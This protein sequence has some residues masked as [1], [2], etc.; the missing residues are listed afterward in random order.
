MERWP[1]GSTP[2]DQGRW[3]TDH[4]DGTLMGHLG[5]RVLEVSKEKTVVELPVHPG[6]ATPSGHVHAGSMVSLA[7]TA[8]TYAAVAA[9]GRDITLDEI[10]VAVS[11]STQIVANVRTGTLRAESM[12]AHPGRTLV[13]V[14]TRVT[15]DDGKLLALVNSTHF[16]R[17][18]N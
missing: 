5:M 9:T 12:V 16:V 3:M 1:V 18:A 13:A 7:D 2:E 8:A 10:P 4:F 17:P 6:L 14:T 15:A 11:I